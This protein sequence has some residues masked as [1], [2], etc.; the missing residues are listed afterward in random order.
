MAHNYSNGSGS[1]TTLDFSDTEIRSEL[2][3]LGYNNINDEQFEEFKKDLLTLVQVDRSNSSSSRYDISVRSHDQ[4]PPAPRSC[5][6]YDRLYEPPLLS[7]P[8]LRGKENANSIYRLHPSLKD[9]RPLSTANRHCGATDHIVTASGDYRFEGEKSLPIRTTAYTYD[10]DSSANLLERRHSAEGVRSLAINRLYDDTSL[11]NGDSHLDD[12]W[13]TND[14]SLTPELSSRR[15]EPSQDL[16]SSDL[17]HDTDKQLAESFNERLNLSQ[18]SQVS[19]VKRKIS[20]KLS[21][22][23]SKVY[24]ESYMKTDSDTDTESECSGET[25]MRKEMVNYSTSER[26]DKQP[27]A[28]RPSSARYDKSV[29][30]VR[31]AVIWPEPKPITSR[32]LVRSDPVNRYLR[33]QQEWHKTKVPEE[34][35][36]KNLR[37][38]VRE[39]MLY[40]DVIYEK[41]QKKFVTNKYVVPTDKKRKDL[42]WRIRA[43]MAAGILPNTH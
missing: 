42:R 6:K 1:N 22:G 21:D 7:E 24:E 39:Q 37:W 33:Y 3:R 17:A 43:D 4:L 14:R 27:Q 20:T 25:R 18:A 32:N 15:P 2:S 8:S 23:T 12:Y 19:L 11:G 26:V 40:K 30:P 16:P 28:V 9:R 41:P 38:S 13:Y 34:K 31:S 5:N 35:K 36:H 29:D 10:I